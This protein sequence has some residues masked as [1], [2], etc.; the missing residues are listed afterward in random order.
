M[1]GRVLNNSPTFIVDSRNR[2]TGVTNEF[3]YIINVKTD[4]KF[5]NFCVVQA[6]IPKS[7]Y[8][9]DSS[10]KDTTF[11]LKEGSSQVVVTVPN[12]NYNVFS[13][14]PV[15]TA[16]L[17]AASPNGYTYSISYPN[18]QV[19]AQ[20]NKYTYSVSGNSGVQP[21]FIFGPD[22]ISRSITNLMGFLPDDLTYNFSGNM[23]ISNVTVRFQHTF[24][25]QIKSSAARQPNS[26]DTDTSVLAT[27]PVGDVVDGGMIVFN[28][29]ELNDASVELTNPSSNVFD[30]SLYDDNDELINLQGQDWS[31][32]VMLYDYN[33]VSDMQ[34]NDLH[35]KYLEEP[36]KDY[37]VQT[38]DP[39]E[40]INPNRG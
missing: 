1:S 2:S 28:L 22:I 7:Y 10:R 16:A 35:L 4:H 29:I 25:L 20:T 11:I 8:L 31:M 14:Q 12:G 32:R 6:N 9:I 27:I 39:T 37:Y 30:F 21:S 40:G 13:F 34:I 24:Y 38:H 26:L 23:L 36:V 18:G 33:N 19:A 15:L 17:N 3:T 5:D